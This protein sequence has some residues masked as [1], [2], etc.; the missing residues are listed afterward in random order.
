IGLNGTGS[1]DLTVPFSTPLG[2]DYTIRVTS[3][4]YPACTD[5]SDA[6]FKIVPALTV[7]S[8]TDGETFSLGSDFPTRWTYTGN[9]G[10]TVK[11]EVLKAT[12]LLKTLTGILIDASESSPYLVPIPS[13]TPLG[14]D[15][16]I[17]VTSESYPA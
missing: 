8:P 13:S 15:Y 17:Q 1:L 12:T 6:S 2:D 3:T 7:V 4:R 16:W 5:T 9:P 14:S 10:P 11:I